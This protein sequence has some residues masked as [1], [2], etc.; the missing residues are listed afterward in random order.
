VPWFQIEETVHGTKKWVTR[1]EADDIASALEAVKDC[2]VPVL[3][4]HFFEDP[5]PVLDPE[6][7]EYG[8]NHKT[9]IFRIKP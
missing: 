6:H 7:M 2:T 1:V 5:D 3:A 4:T 9:T 8:T